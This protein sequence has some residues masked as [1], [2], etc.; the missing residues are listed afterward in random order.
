MKL[1]GLIDEDFV[2]YKK[3]SMFLIFP[4]C[5]W[6]CEKECGIKCC[7]NSSVAKLPIIEI[8]TDKLIKR[9]LENP[10]THAIVLGGL[11]PLDSFDEVIELIS[12]LRENS[13]DDIVIYTGYKEEELNQKLEI[14][15][16]YPEIIVKFGRF[17][18]N[19]KHRYDEVLGVE[20]A[21]ENQFARRIS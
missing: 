13:Q 9:Y 8:E 4:H 6:K 11:E 3:A 14:L 16:K 20:L 10:I 15:K 5:T 1:R 2:N 21:S 19:A 17:I 18:P 12:K 7:Q